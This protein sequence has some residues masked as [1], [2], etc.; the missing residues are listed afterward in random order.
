MTT[1]GESPRLTAD[2]R[3]GPYT[4]LAVVG[5]VAALVTGQVVLAAVA[6]P[7][8]VLVV[9][10]LADRRP[11]VVTVM[12]VDAPERLLEGDE[13]I[14][15]IELAWTGPADVD[16]LHDG[17]RGSSF[18]SAPGVAHRGADGV[19]I[20]LRAV[21]DRWGRHDLG[22]LTVRARRPGGM[23][24]WDSMLALD[25]A[26]RVLPAAAR[27]DELLHPARPRAAAGQHV[28]PV[29]GAGTDFADLRPYTPGDRLRDLSWTASAR[30]EQPWVVVH[31]P[32]R[33]AA[34]VL[35]LDAFV[36]VGTPEGSLERA[37]RVVW[38]VARHHL[39]AGDRVGLLA[40]GSAPTWLAP[41]AGRRARWQVLDALLSVGSTV[42]G[43]APRRSTP[44]GPAAPGTRRDVLLPADAVVLG[45]SPLQ[46]D[47]FVHAVAHHA[48]V[49]H[50]AA[51][52]G[53]ALDDLLP[54]VGDEVERAARRLWAAETRMR[55]TVLGRA[56]VPSVTV[57]D[58]PSPAIDLLAVRTRWT[59]VA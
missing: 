14:L 5:L 16:V 41:V 23:L 46:S 54:P 28:A 9:R 44:G 26:V 6:A 56:G 24:V 33:S 21:A 20:E 42:A 29:R 59:R 10:A 57:R 30:T 58:D 34:V 31:H 17:L 1:S 47:A 22:T 45:V 25:G 12:R 36:E 27:L 15:R 8:G 18:R 40:M 7:A 43:S 37:A 49:G 13:W 48:R 53:V 32:E 2:R 39:A 38:A 19:A 51:V 50:P 11:V 35:L 3:L 4:V 55:T 52:V